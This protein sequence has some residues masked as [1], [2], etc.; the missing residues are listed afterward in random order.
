MTQVQPAFAG[1]IPET[2]D[3]CMGP[4]FFEPYAQDLASR[5][6]ALAPARVLEL[7]C[8]TGIATRRLRD[9]LSPQAQLVATD[10]NQPMIDRAA[11]IP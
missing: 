8:G 4:I 3:R 1:R 5:L 10:L 7:A 11:Q 6:R 9:A 2:Y